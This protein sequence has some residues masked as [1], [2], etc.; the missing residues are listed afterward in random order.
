LQ[1]VPVTVVIVKRHLNQL[2]FNNNNNNNNLLI[3]DLTTMSPHNVQQDKRNKSGN[4][5]YYS[6]V[7]LS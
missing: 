5:N 4:Y 3:K 6:K 2:L 1:S 7:I